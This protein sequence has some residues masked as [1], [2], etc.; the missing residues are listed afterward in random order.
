[1]LTFGAWSAAVI[2]IAIATTPTTPAA[3][4]TT[5]LET[6]LATRLVATAVILG[7]ALR[8]I[9]RITRLIVAAVTVFALVTATIVTAA[10]A[11]ALVLVAARLAIAC[12]RFR[13]LRL[14]RFA[15]EES[16]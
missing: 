11:I 3:A 7:A 2:A 10:I 13:L 12:V 14:S 16:L 6:L 9:P 15:A 5:A 8:F 4:A 1:M